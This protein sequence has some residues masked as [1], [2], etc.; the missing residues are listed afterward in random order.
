MIQEHSTIRVASGPDRPRCISR[1]V[2][3]FP[4]GHGLSYTTFSLSSLSVPSD[5]INLPSKTNFSVKLKNTGT[6]SGAQVVQAYITP[7]A[8]GSR[9]T[10]PK[11]ELKAFAKVYLEAGEE[12]TVEL[13]VEKDAFGYWDDRAGNWVA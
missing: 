7:P 10:R 3:L 11:K 12:K 6:K 8:G 4:F 9:L 1:R 5:A 2:P 13:S